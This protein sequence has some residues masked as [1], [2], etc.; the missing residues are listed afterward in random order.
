MELMTGA[1]ELMIASRLL[2]GIPFVQLPA[3]AQLLFTVPVHVVVA[4]TAEKVT[5]LEVAGLFTTQFK[6][7]V[8]TQEIWSLADKGVVDVNEDEVAPITSTL[9]IF[10]WYWGLDPPFA[11]MDEN[12]GP[13]QLDVLDWATVMEAEGWVTV[14]VIPELVMLDGLAH[15]AL[16][17]RITSTTC[18]LL[19]EEVTN[20]F[21]LEF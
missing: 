9:F 1:P 21:E 20:M 5:E 8:R 6:L 17:V 16:L 3:L 11:T 7:E 13:V 12:T 14:M 10:H 18:A 15:T 4:G 2:V 19:N